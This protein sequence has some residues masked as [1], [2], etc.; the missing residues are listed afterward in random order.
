M[1]KLLRYA[2]Q[3]GVYLL[4]AVAF[5][6][7]S[8]SP[9]YTH[10]PPDQALITLSFSHGGKPAGPC[11]RLSADEIAKLPPNM[12]RPMDCPRERLP[13][14]VELALDGAVLYRRVLAP[15]GLWGDGPARAY[16]RFRVAP[17]P[18]R[19]GARL[20]DSARTEGFDYAREGEI[21]LAPRQNFV[22]DFRAETG[23]FLFK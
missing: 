16:A 23:G 18:H 5:G 11:R 9:S 3:A 13:V 10:F 7:L 21:T 12:R 2:G 22:V 1:T 8:D 15:S 4:V 19:L 20:A 17:G 14:R 6:Y